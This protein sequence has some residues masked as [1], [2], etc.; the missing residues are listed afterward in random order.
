MEY[1]NPFGRKS[2]RA[3]AAVLL[4]AGF[5]S[6][7]ACGRK[8]GGDS[9]EGAPRGPGEMLVPAAGPGTSEA[10]AGGKAEIVLS[11]L[12]P[13]RIEPPSLSVRAP[14]GRA[15]GDVDVRW[16]VNGIE[17]ETGLRLPPSRFRRGD[18]IQATV[19]LRGDGEDTVITT[20]EVQARNSPPV[21]SAVRIE[22]ADP[23]SGG[24]VRAIVESRDADDDPLK[25]RYQWFVDDAPVPGDAA[26]L[27]L[28][29]VKRGSWL[30]VKATP[31]DGTSDGAWNESPR[32]RVANALP[33]VKST[34]PKEVPPGGNFVYRIEAEDPDGDPL[35]YALAKGPQGMVLNGSTVE[36]PVGKEYLGQPVEF[37]VEVSDGQEGKTVQNVSLT[38]RPPRNP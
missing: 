12:V 20:R 10:P 30:H 32:Y 25:I 36:W 34:V 28:K 11:P 6:V 29:G 13:S 38:I 17:T 4:V 19:T 1:V 37:S 9:P 3:A 15:E 27:V 7:A 2:R 8:E 35:T 16:F 5:L 24:T 33:V 23:V 21:V 14:G 31:N 22:P 18:R 26:E